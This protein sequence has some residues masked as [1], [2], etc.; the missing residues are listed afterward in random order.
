MNQFSAFRHAALRAR[1]FLSLILLAN[2]LAGG[3]R[4]A[5]EFVGREEDRIEE[6]SPVAVDVDEGGAARERVARA[7]EQGRVVGRAQRGPDVRPGGA[8]VDAAPDEPA[9]P[10]DEDEAG[11]KDAT[12]EVTAEYGY[13]YLKSESGV[14]RLVRIS[15]QREQEVVF[16]IGRLARDEKP[17][18]TVT[19]FAPGVAPLAPETMLQSLDLAIDEAACD[20]VEL[21]ERGRSRG[22]SCGGREGVRPGGRRGRTRGRPTSCNPA[23]CSRWSPPRAAC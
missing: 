19:R 23:T 4:A 8:V 11:I 12:L 2:V 6:R 14:H 22:R 17:T 10:G 21:D 3:A 18:A 16:R 1:F 9:A 13:G 7:G 15:L 5:D 20:A